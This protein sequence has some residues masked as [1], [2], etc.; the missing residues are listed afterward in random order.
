MTSMSN[1]LSQAS[2]V[3]DAK[4]LPFHFNDYKS[5]QQE[6]AAF[7]G[8]HDLQSNQFITP[9]N[10]QD[11]EVDMDEEDQQQQQQQPDAVMD[12]HMTRFLDSVA[13]EEMI[14]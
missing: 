12:E 6:S 10:N 4:R 11:E 14:E 8:Q 3:Y 7:Q 9:A 13:L 5:S 1:L 2:P